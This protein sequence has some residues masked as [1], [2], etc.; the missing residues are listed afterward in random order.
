MLR[1]PI[2]LDTLEQ[3]RRYNAADTL[4]SINALTFETLLNLDEALTRE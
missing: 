4:A 2:M 1:P 3:A